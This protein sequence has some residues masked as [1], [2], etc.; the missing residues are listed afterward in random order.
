M[1]YRVRRIE[2]DTAIEQLKDYEFALI[3]MISGILLCR[4]SDLPEVDWEECM[5]ARFFDKDKE[6][7]LYREDENLEAVEIVE[8]NREDCLI[9][10]YQLANRFKAAGG[11]LC[12]HEYLDYDEDGQATV[13]LT[14]L[15]GIEEV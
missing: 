12:V 3:Y 2:A 4:T 14:R 5:E 7:H 1:S 13:S 9:R 15:A 10:K 8:E 6:L 11:L